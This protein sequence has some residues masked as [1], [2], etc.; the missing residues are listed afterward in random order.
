MK[1]LLKDSSSINNQVIGNWIGI[2]A[3]GY[4]MINPKCGVLINNGSHS[5][6]VK[7]NK[8]AWNSTWKGVHVTSGST[9]QAGTNTLYAAVA[10]SAK[11]A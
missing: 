5:N 1:L 11:L 4:S 9:T 3:N 6:I 10:T 8:I 7:N 2:C